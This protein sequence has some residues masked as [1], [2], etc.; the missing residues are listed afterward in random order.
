M[1][2]LPKTIKKFTAIPIKISDILHGDRKVNPTVHLE[3]QKITNSK[4]NTEQK[5]Q[6]WQYHNT[7][8]QTTLKSHN[9]KIVWY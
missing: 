9:N 8:F 7:Q 4:G 2:I 6:C 5:E 1:V 3:E